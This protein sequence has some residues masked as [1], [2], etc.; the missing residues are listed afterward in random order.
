MSVEQTDTKRVYTMDE[1]RRIVLPL[2]EK[3]CI[4]KV[5]VFGSYARGEADGG[6]DTDL[7]VDRRG[8][9]ITRIFGL[10]GDVADATGKSVDIYDVSELLS[11]P[12][13]DAVLS[14]V[15]RL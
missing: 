8:G 15:V 12:F 10:G 13:K 7:L 4:P 1:L 2:A 14:E 3:R 5:S 6:S 9:R 11:E